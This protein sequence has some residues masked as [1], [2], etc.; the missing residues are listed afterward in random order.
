MEK[1][2]LQFDGVDYLFEDMTPQQ[3]LLVK[4]VADI[5]QKIANVEFN[6]DQLQVTKNAFT[7]ML[8]EALVKKDE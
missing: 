8:K 1:T 6:L 2:K 5:E 3:Q 4:H 7:Q